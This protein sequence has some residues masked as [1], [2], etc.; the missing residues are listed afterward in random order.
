MQGPTEVTGI[1]ATREELT[2]AIAQM[3]SKGMSP[4]QIA[5]TTDVSSSTIHGILK[6]IREAQRTARERENKTL[7]SRAWR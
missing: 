3:H 5:K 2:T 4:K 7:I 1:Y 6:K